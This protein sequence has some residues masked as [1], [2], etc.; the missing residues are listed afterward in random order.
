MSQSTL[1]CEQAAVR[2]WILTEFMA[3][4]SCILFKKKESLASVGSNICDHDGEG[5]VEHYVEG[6]RN[7]WRRLLSDLTREWKHGQIVPLSS[8]PLRSP[9]LP[10]S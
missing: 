3:G 6:S 4:L 2:N 5:Q 9:P 7:T 10:M 1:R 8:P